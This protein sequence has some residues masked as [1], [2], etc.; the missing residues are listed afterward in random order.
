M[1]ARS[2]AQ[3]MYMAIALHHPS[4]LRKKIKMSK[5]KLREYA[6]T[7]RKNLP[8]KKNKPKLSLPKTYR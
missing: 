4:K 6:S 3:Q 1:P 7:T 8:K 2:R 5:K